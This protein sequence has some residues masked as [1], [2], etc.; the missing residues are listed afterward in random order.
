MKFK[1]GSKEAKLFMAKL[2]A[3]RGKKK[4]SGTKK[5]TVKKSKAKTKKIHTDVKS[6]NYRI[7]ISGAG[8]YAKF[9]ISTIKALAK[10]LKKPL[11]TIQKAVYDTKSF[12]DIISNSFDQGKTPL[13]TAKILK[14]ELVP[15]KQ[16]KP[17][18]AFVNLLTKKGKGQSSTGS[19]ANFPMKLPATVTIGGITEEN[20]I[21]EIKTIRYNIERLNKSL[22]EANK[23]LKTR[24]Y[25][26]KD[27]GYMRANLKDRIK[28]VKKAILIEKKVLKNLLQIKKIF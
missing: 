10:L 15:K 2:R 12:L 16:I 18:D 27:N 17:L 28:F 24:K 11:K 23:L 8:D 3:S 20:L 22:Q 6:H 5:K 14:E 4:L 25:T 9:E 21:D 19:K 13:Q 26:N 1:K 7:S